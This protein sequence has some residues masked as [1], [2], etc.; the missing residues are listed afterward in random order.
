MRD[1]D[2]LP[3]VAVPVRVWL[4]DGEWIAVDDRNAVRQGQPV[5]LASSGTITRRLPENNRL[6]IA[7]RPR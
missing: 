4:G 1:A 2:R 6:L 3:T 7:G 5:P